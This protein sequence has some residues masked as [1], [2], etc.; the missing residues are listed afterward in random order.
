MNEVWICS[1]KRTAIGAFMGSLKDIPAVDLGAIVVKAILAETGVPPAQISELI[2]GC[3]LPA[4]QGMNPARQIALKAGLPVESTAFTVNRVCGS[5]LQAVV[6]GAQEILLGEADLI[7][8][9]GIENMS[10]APYL[11]PKARA[12]FRLGNE[13]I[14]DGMIG[15]GLWD[16]FTDEHMGSTAENLAAKYGISRQEQDEFALASQRKA[17][18]A[19]REGRF[20]DEIVPVLA[21]QGKGESLSFQM[22]ECVR[23]DASPEKLVRLRPAFKKDGTVTAG[24]SSG[25]NDGAAFVLLVSGNRVKELGLKPLAI[26]RS[27]AVAGVEPGEMGLGPVPATRKALT[28][29]SVL[30]DQV[31]FLELNEAFAAQSLAVL[32]ELQISPERV[33]LNGGAIALGHPIGASGARILVTLL[34]EMAHR[35]YPT[36]AQVCTGLAALCIG[37]G[38][39]IALLAER[40]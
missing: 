30:L 5:G 40:V 22:D 19:I 32:R 9:G 14:V 34:H 28:K 13:T 20:K 23:L 10:R 6:S 17:G 37:G 11:L 4:G 25:I 7:L 8:A 33:N 16:V 35:P 26:I 12:G 27:W 21:P 39:G 15:D 38:Q 18:Q 31:E 24:N 3:A 29:A 2:A 1:A 36:G